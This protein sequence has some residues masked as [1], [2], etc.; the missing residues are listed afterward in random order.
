VD[1]HRV[2]GDDVLCLGHGGAA[3]NAVPLPATHAASGRTDTVKAIVQDTYGSP[4]VLE[5]RDIDPPVVNDDEV[6]PPAF[7]R[8]RTAGVRPRCERTLAHPGSA[9]VSLRGRIP[10]TRRGGAS[11]CAIDRAYR[12][13]A[14]WR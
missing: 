3:G 12:S 7:R 10:P 2:A 6:H 5:L 9:L 13:P 14:R 1:N 4:D 11:V 8:R